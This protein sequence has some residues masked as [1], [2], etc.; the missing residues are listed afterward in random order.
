MTDGP[1]SSLDEVLV[2]VGAG[3]RSASADARLR[4]LLEIARDDDLAARVVVE[5]LIPG[6]LTCARR[7]REPEAFEELLGGLWIAIRT[8]NP[9]RR[10]SCVA[11][12]LLA[13]AQYHAFRRRHRQRSNDERPT[14][15]DDRIVDDRLPHPIDELTDLL[16]EAR[17]SGMDPADLE[18]VRMLV[19][20]P[21]TEDIAAELDV[22][23]RTVRNR[24]DRVTRQLRE[25][26]LSC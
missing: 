21:S 7:R 1:P 22:T 6:L 9:E 14:E 26:A 15:I 8:F 2:A 25:L 19:A 18:L 16:T 17:R 3:D 5:R 24:R 11:V 13:D 10:P 4:R 12:S 23:S 20:R